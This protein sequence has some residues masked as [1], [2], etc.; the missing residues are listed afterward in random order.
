MTTLGLQ[1]LLPLVAGWVNRNQPEVI[2]FLQAEN[3]LLREQLGPRRPRFS[4]ADRP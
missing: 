3:R 1:L 2:D 4:D